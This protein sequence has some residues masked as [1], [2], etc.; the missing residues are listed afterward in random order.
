MKS[1]LS[2][3][4]ILQAEAMTKNPTIGSLI[5]KNEQVARNRFK[6]TIAAIAVASGSREVPDQILLSMLWEYFQQK[7]IGY[8]FEDIK[9]AFVMN[10]S[11]ELDQRVQHFQLI[12]LNFISQVMDLYLEKKIQLSK[13]ITALLPPPEPQQIET[14]EDC[15]NGLVAYVKKHGEMPTF[16][17][18]LRVFDHME[19]CLMIEETLESK[20]ELFAK[21]YPKHQAKAELDILNARSAKE[22]DDILENAKLQ[23]QTECRKILIEKYLPK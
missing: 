1:S 6:E 7:L 19:E 12:D 23:A 17:S 16:W 8:T 3:Q 4:E 15:F 14:D 21:I 20:R 18:W 10:A 13:R 22:R 2:R 11:G 9:L 5:R